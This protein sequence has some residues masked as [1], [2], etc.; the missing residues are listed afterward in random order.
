MTLHENIELFKDAV[1]ASSEHKGL[2]EIFIEKDYWLTVALNKIYQSEVAC[3][4]V[5]KGGTS[6]SKCY[7]NVN[8]FSEDID[9]VLLRQPDENGN[10]LK[11]KLKKITSAVSEV[12][13]EMNIDG[14]T[15]KKGMIRKTAHSYTHNFEGDFGQIRD[16]VIVECTWLGYYEPYTKRMVKSF[17]YEMMENRGQQELAKEYDLMPFEVLVLEPSRT[18][19]EK[20]MSLVR[21]S[22]TKSAEDDLKK[23]IRHVYDLHQLLTQKDLYEFFNSVDFENML[24]KVANDDVD[25][26]KNNNEWLKHHPIKSKIFSDIDLIWTKLKSAYTINFKEMVYGDFPDEKELLATLKSIKKRISSV[27]WKLKEF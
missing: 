11:L 25:S 14:I 23:K 13:P 21:F 1:R 27:E 15:N 26:F 4:V 18:I 5:F 2:P 17:I 9:L 12:L 24:L 8:R 22:Y 7:D 6:L 19:C 20:I 10:Q 3:Y 16:V